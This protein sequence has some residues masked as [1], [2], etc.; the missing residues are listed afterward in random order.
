MLYTRRGWGLG[1]SRLSTTPIKM[2]NR[3]RLQTARGTYG[4]S[5]VGVDDRM[6]IGSSYYTTKSP[7]D[8]LIVQGNVGIGTDSPDGTLHV[9]ADNR[10][11]ITTGTV[12]VFTGLRAPSEGRAQFVLSSS[13]SDLVIASSA[14]NNNHGSTLS[15]AAVNPSNTA[16]YRKFVINQGNWDLEKIS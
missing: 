12:P 11:H 7:T 10:V 15:F 5:F 13:Y 6:S 8:G 14:V 3:Y 2:G 4:R 9:K 1:F 16:E